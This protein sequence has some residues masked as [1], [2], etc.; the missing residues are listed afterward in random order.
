MSP[1][2][3]SSME[4]DIR[5]STESPKQE[6]TSPPSCDVKK[7]TWR[8]FF[9]EKILSNKT[10]FKI[11]ALV[12]V[13]VLT[14]IFIFT[15]LF[16]EKFL[17][18]DNNLLLLP[19]VSPLKEDPKDI[20]PVIEK[21]IISQNLSIAQQKDEE[22][23]DKELANTQNF[24]IKPLLEEIA[25]LKQLISDL[26]KNY[27][28][29]VTQL[30]KMETL[31]ANPLR[32]PNTQRMVSLLILKNALDKG[33]YS[34]LNTTMQENFSVLKPC[35]ATLMQ[36]ANIKIPTTIEI[37]AKFPKVS[38]EMVF[39]SESLEKDSGFANYL[40]FQLTRL[41]KVRPIG[42][43]IEGDAITDVIARI[44]NNLKTGD[45]VKAAAEWDKIPEKA[46]QPSMFLRNAL[47]AHICSDAILKEEM[48]KIP[49]TDLP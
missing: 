4:K 49:Q 39:A 5:R 32:N 2:S 48:A 34:S 1:M 41:V 47:E 15:A 38:E 37:L 27:Q 44:E 25:S 28:D 42:G 21:E 45:L 19:S 17:R 8:K 31:T 43:N 9:W 35:T 16:T 40:L 33:E 20:S 18:T 10:F 14:F 7:I 12:C 3:D 30:T 11:L 22:T 23:A 13:I 46:R 24:N 26:S 6:E 29:I 36:F